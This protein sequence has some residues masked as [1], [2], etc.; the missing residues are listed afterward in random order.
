M[1]ALPRVLNNIIKCGVCARRGDFLAQKQAHVGGV[2]AQAHL[3]AA[4]QHPAFDY[5]THHLLTIL[6]QNYVH[7]R[8]TVLGA[9]HFLKLNP[10]LNTPVERV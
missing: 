2:V 8:N 1:N 6:I 5:K 7:A 10:I 3:G 4:T 9:R